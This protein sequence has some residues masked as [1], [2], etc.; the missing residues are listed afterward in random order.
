MGVSRQFQTKLNPTIIERIKPL[1]GDEGLHRRAVAAIIGI[2][3]V[4]FSRW[5]YRGARNERGDKLFHDFYLAVNAAEATFMQSAHRTLQGA[6]GRNPKILMWLLSRR[7]AD[8]YGRKDNVDQ[9]T[10]ED[11]AQKTESMR[12]LLIE[13]LEKLIPEEPEPPALVAETLVDASPAAA[14]T[15]AP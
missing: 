9:P 6:A 2:D 1:L 4:T 14:E 11:Q 8:L 7:F 15:G 5:Y 10:P 13:R 3:E 12:E